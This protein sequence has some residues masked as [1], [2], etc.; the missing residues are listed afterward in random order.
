MSR[1]AILR[2]Y[3]ELGGTLAE[4]ED[5]KE[6]AD[7]ARGGDAKAREAFRS[8]GRHYVAGAKDLIMEL[9]VTDLLF[10][11]Q[12]AKSFDLMED[13]IKN[14]LGDAVDVSVLDDIQGTVLVGIASL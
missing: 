11:G 9:G 7:K 2:V 3:A 1:R 10:A 4:G 14:G 5:V 12:I 6:I 13:E 8:A